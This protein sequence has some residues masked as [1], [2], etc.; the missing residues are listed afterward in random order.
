MKKPNKRE[1]DVLQHFCGT[2]EPWGAFPGAGETTKQSLLA[3]GWI[4][5]NQD[6]HYPADYF[7]ITEAGEAAAYE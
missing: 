5:P 6:P 1:R 3:A 4:R 7:E 2:P